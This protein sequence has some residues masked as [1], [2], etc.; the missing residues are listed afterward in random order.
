MFNE[1]IITAIRNIPTTT[2]HVATPSW[3][4][5]QIEASYSKFLATR[6]RDA[7]PSITTSSFAD[8]TFK[9][10]EKFIS[11]GL[12]S[13]FSLT[14]S[15][16]V[17]GMGTNFHGEIFETRE[18]FEEW[19]RVEFAFKVKQIAY[20]YNHCLVLT[21]GGD[22]YSCGSNSYGQLVRIVDIHTFREMP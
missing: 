18:P 17:Y 16:N 8:I 15:G 14:N 9:N 22:V 13:T 21:A 12:W 2:L 10:D 7:L 5:K 1:G 4:T 3:N 19:V 6:N 20:N 11:S